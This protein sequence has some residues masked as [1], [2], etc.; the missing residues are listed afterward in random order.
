MLP[1]TDESGAFA[2]AE[3]VRQNIE[4]ISLNHEGVLVKFTISI[5]ISTMIPSAEASFID[6]NENA[7]Q[8]LYSA[9]ESGRNKVVVF[10]A[11]ATNADSQKVA[12]T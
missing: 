6:L 8:A 2:I 11:P 1:N 12:F 3:D 9:K 10:G 7:D 4:N 5:G